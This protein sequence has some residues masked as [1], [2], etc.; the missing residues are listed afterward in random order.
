M[1]YSALYILL[2]PYCLIPIALLL[3][4]SLIAVSLSKRICALQREDI[5]NRKGSLK[6]MAFALWGVSTA[7]MYTSLV[8]M[9]LISYNIP[10]FAGIHSEWGI[11]FEAAYG[12]AAVYIVCWMLLY[13]AL[14][15]P[16]WLIVKNK[17]LREPG[18][19]F[20]WY[21][22]LS[23]IILAALLVCFYTTGLG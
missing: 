7:A 4:I 23:T 15:T 13:T 17:I 11:A 3:G 12:T 10:F 6:P 8:A 18:R 22:L 19:F 14:Q 1:G 2:P 16:A 20:A 5:A 9:L 21:L